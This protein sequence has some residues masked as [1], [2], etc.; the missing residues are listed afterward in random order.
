MSKSGDQGMQTF[1][2]A[3]YSLFKNGQITREDALAHADSRNDLRLLMKLDQDPGD[4]A[5][6]LNFDRTGM[7]SSR[8]LG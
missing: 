8:P 1:D 7:D 4:S 6:D 3:L 2:Q 5:P